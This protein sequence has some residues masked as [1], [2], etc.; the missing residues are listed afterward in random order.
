MGA[1]N[2]W[3]KVRCQ[4]MRPSVYM[5]MNPKHGSHNAIMQNM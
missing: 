3:D 1:L 2:P 5:N 4:L